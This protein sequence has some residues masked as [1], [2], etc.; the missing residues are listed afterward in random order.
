MWKNPAFHF[1]IWP[2]IQLRDQYLACYHVLT[3]IT[4]FRVHWYYAPLHMDWILWNCFLCDA[5]W[6]HSRLLEHVKQI[7]PR[8][9]GSHNVDKALVGAC[10]L[11][12]LIYHSRTAVVTQTV[13]LLDFF[14]IRQVRNVDAVTIES[15]LTSCLIHSLVI[16][17]ASTS[18]VTCFSL[19]EITITSNWPGIL[20][21]YA[22]LMESGTSFWNWV[23]D[24][25]I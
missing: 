2:M 12:L 23:I 10:Y 21:V 24:I 17:G 25:I 9:V 1:G 5:C 8:N 11:D 19:L 13:K 16:W 7:T 20:W 4:L 18:V 14:L 15:C 3:S 6:I 22:D